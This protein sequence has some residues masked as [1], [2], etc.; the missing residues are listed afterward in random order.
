MSSFEPQEMDL[1]QFLKEFPEAQLTI[2]EKLPYHFLLAT[3]ILT[4]QKAILNIEYSSEELRE[5]VEGFVNMIPFTWRD[6]QFEEDMQNAQIYLFQDQRPAFC[7]VVATEQICED[8]HI[9]PYVYVLTFDYFKVFNAVVN[10][11]NRRHMLLKPV[12]KEIF[13]GHKAKREQENI[14]EEEMFDEPT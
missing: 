5:A 11:L 14:P 12:Y 4:F 2:R 3:M 8:L 10:L 13:T 1:A 9:D 6:E 7:G